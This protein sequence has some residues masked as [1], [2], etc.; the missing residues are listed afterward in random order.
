LP[1]QKSGA[2]AVLAELERRTRG[3]RRI[4]TVDPHAEVPTGSDELAERDSAL[5]QLASAAVTGLAPTAPE[6]RRR[7]V[8]MAFDGRPNRP[9]GGEPTTPCMLPKFSTASLGAPD[10]PRPTQGPIGTS[11]PVRWVVTNVQ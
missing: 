11:A 5:A 8:E 10:L 7:L 3:G 1:L 6:V 4:I 2:D 9:A